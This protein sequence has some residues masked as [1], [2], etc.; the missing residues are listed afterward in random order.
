MRNNH[1]TSRSIAHWYV[2][3]PKGSELAAIN[4]TNGNTGFQITVKVGTM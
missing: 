3:Q 4:K 2:R 1:K